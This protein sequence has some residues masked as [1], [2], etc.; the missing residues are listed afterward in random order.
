[1]SNAPRTKIRVPAQPLL[2]YIDARGGIPAIAGLGVL[3]VEMSEAYDQPDQI[4]LDQT[5]EERKRYNALERRLQRAAKDGYFSYFAADEIACD[6]LHVHP[7]TIYGTWYEM[8]EDDLL[9]DRLSGKEFV[10]EQVA[11]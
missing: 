3:R 7:S 2:D 1:M 11:A 9:Q 5:D 8:A 4:V 6:Y 10:S